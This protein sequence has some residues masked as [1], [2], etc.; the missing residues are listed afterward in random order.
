MAPRS[1]L[2]S[3]GFP[4]SSR[5]WEAIRRFIRA[6]WRRTP[7]LNIVRTRLPATGV[8]FLY[9]CHM[10]ELTDNGFVEG[11]GQA[12]LGNAVLWVLVRGQDNVADC[13]Y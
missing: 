2:A 9:A 12:L 5:D 3:N 13:R 11:E 4:G 10:A 1:L 6:S 8:A 7:T